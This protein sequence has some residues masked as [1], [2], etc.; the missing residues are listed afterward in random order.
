MRSVDALK[1]L[2]PI[3]VRNIIR[4]PLLRWMVFLPLL[5]GVLIRWGVPILSTYLVGR[6]QFDLVPYYHLVMSAILLQWPILFGMIIGFLLLDQ[7]DDQTITALQVTPLTLTGYLIYRISLPLVVSIM[8]TL[9]SFPI[10]GL[11]ELRFLPLFLAALLAAPLAPMFALFLA[12][13]AENKVQGFALTKA[14]GIVLWPPVFAYFIDSPWKLAFGIF[15]TYWPMKFFW[16][17]TSG[18]GKIWI[19]FVVGMLYQIFV[20][21]VL[22]KRF[23]KVMHR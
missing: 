7:R 13:F 16:L 8:I 14:V 12:T 21:W 17:L 11:V 20:L 23:N 2:G 15:P 19:Y 5:I 18:G 6:F 1:A 4:D 3:D 10:A 22:L 9:I